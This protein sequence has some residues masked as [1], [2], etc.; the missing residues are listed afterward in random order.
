M[1]S[2]EN[3]DAYLNIWGTDGSCQQLSTCLSEPGSAFLQGGQLTQDSPA[4]SQWCQLFLCGVHKVTSPCRSSI[5]PEETAHFFPQGLWGKRYECPERL[6]ALWQR[7]CVNTHTGH[8]GPKIQGYHWNRDFFF[9]IQ[10]AQTQS[11]GQVVWPTDYKGV[12]IYQWCCVPCQ[13]HWNN[14]LIIYSKWYVIITQPSAS[15]DSRAFDIVQFACTF[16]CLCW[17]LQAPC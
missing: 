11:S 10:Q 7:A 13:H 2:I 5:L 4:A 3:N 1:H 12:C 14:S 9:T 8:L 16:G 15:F 6:T 17:N